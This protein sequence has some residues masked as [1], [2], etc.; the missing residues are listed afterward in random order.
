MIFP[1]ERVVRGNMQKPR[2]ATF[3]GRYHGDQPIYSEKVPI[4][5]KPVPVLDEAGEPVYKVYNNG[6][7]K[8]RTKPNITGYRDREYV[9][10]DLG[11][12]QTPKNYDFAPT[13]AELARIQA[14]EATQPDKL[15]AFVDKVNRVFDKLGLSDDDVDRLAAVAEDEE[16]GNA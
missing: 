2:K 9:I 4:Y 16:Q 5:G 15:A 7:K 10:E 11:N 8:L 14:V 3:T 1:T 12:G 6:S 13:A